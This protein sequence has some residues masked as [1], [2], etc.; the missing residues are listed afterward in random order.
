MPETMMSRRIKK[1]RG[2]FDSFQAFVVKIQNN[3]D[4]VEIEMKPIHTFNKHFVI[5]FKFP[6]KYYICFFFFNFE[7]IKRFILNF[8]AEFC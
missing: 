4:I 3:P 8:F 5:L 6:Q 1:N 7:R 2:T